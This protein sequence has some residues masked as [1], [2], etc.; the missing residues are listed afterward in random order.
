[1]EKWTQEQYAE[2]LRDMKQAAHDRLWLYID[3]NAKEL[4]EE[5]EPGV[6]NLSSVCRAMTDEMLEGDSYEV[7]PR[8]KTNIAGKLTVRYYVDNLHP[9]RRKYSEVNPE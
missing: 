7:K 1:M 8:V 5:C 2:K 3:V 9:S 4:M 6:K